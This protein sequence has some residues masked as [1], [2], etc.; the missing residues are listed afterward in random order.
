M[1][2]TTQDGFTRLLGE[3]LIGVTL[4]YWPQLKE[5]DPDV[6][7]DVIAHTVSRDFV[8]GRYA[9][10]ARGEQARDEAINAIAANVTDYA[11]PE[12]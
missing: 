5:R 4:F 9:T 3:R 8:L 6:S 7:Y 11:A 12:E 2:V 1:I 10:L